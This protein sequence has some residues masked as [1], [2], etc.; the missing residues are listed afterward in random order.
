MGFFPHTRSRCSANI[1]F[2]SNPRCNTNES[3]QYPWSIQ[4]WHI[5]NIRLPLIYQQYYSPNSL[6]VL[7]SFEY[8][9]LRA[10]NHG[11]SATQI[12]PDIGY[13]TD[14]PQAVCNAGAIEQAAGFIWP[15]AQIGVKLI[16]CA[17]VRGA[18]CSLSITLEYFQYF[19]EQIGHATY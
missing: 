14:A 15:Q 18:K 7:P 12:V 3:P 13:V 6:G 8:L 2:F 19:G 17:A 10:L 5:R 11:V 9:L 16:G 4:T 1:P